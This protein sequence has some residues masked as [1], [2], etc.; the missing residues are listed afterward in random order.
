MIIIPVYS[1]L[2]TV[3]T[4]LVFGIVFL[5]LSYEDQ[6]L[7][8]K[9]WGWCWIVYSIMFCL[10]FAN[11]QFAFLGD[12][13]LPARQVLSLLSSLFFLSATNYF[14]QQKTS[15][16]V[17][18]CVIASFITILSSMLSMDFYYLTVIPN[19]LFCSGLL[20]ISA[21]IFLS[22]YW[23]QNF[24]EKI[25]A[26]FLIILW[27]VFLNHFGFSIAH[28]S[29]AFYN[30]FVGVFIINLVIVILLIIHFEKTKFIISRQ[31]A[32]FR[33]LVEN[34]TDSMF[35]YNYKKQTF[36]YVSPSI[37]S[38]I[39]ISSTQLY[40]MPERFFDHIETCQED[41][42]VLSLFSKPLTSASNAT[43]CYV[44][45]GMASRW[46]EVHYLPIYDN[47]GILVEVEGILRDITE[48]KLIEKN[49]NSSEVARKE[50]I[51]NISHEIKTPVTLIQ[52]YTESLLNNVVPKSSRQNYLQMIYS[53]TKMLTNLLEDLINVSR[54]TSQTLEYRF[55]E[56]NALEYF[57]KIIDE[58]T[59]QLENSNH[60]FLFENT[61][62]PK[63]IIIFDNSRINQ[64]ISN[65]IDNAIKHTP[66]NGL[67]TISCITYPD[68]TTIQSLKNSESL[69]IA[70]GQ[71]YFTVSDTGTGIKNED[72]P[73]IFDRR[74]QGT[75]TT[76]DSSFNNGSGLGLYI[77]MQIIQQHS[78]KM[79]A[80]NNKNNGAEISFIMPYYI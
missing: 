60:Q 31:A 71:L 18:Y 61:I 17:Y 47:L 54:F 73:F 43:L 23:T 25:F 69:S 55:Y 12:Y 27:A 58:S 32:R 57:S 63:A 1:L 30:Y 29:L 68:E 35:L 26:S 59:L 33:T 45:K 79:L 15:K 42:H 22:H 38:V 65:L 62:D 16:K 10:D 7:Y 39:G 75:T 41:K 70:S 64:V 5:F 76:E 78:G 51:E 40:T 13:F 74:Y 49:L 9:L 20:I 46:S 36:E 72:L 4:T 34:A 28:L 53:K 37:Q 80:K 44:V 50:L 48:Q 8:L 11:L 3:F 24:P 67:I 66:E 52:G 77:S 6:N 14:F 2:S 21:C 56:C 19:I